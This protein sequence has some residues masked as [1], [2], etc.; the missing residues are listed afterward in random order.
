MSDTNAV[1]PVAVLKEIEDLCRGCET[2]LARKAEI[3]NEWSGIAFRLGDDQLLAPMDDVVEILDYPEISTVPLT[4]AWVRGIAN[5]RGNLLPIID[6]NGYLGNEVPKVTGKTRVLVVDSEGVYSGIVVDEVL[7]L[8]HFL[9]EELT[10]ESPGVDGV[11][12]PYLQHGF[13]RGGQVWGVFNVG[14]LVESPAFLQ[15]AV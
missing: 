10:S 2:G 7:G 8:K 14:S 11:L 3:S 9:E 12:Q 15:V 13:R 5:V 1:S 4:Q 6:L